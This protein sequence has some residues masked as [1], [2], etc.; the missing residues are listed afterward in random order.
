[1]RTYGHGSPGDPVDL[2]AIRVLARVERGGH[3]NRLGL[4]AEHAPPEAGTTRQA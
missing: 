3:A 1:M 2:V 4:A